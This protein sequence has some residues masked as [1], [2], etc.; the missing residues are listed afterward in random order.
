M[1][2]S[3]NIVH[4]NAWPFGFGFWLERVFGILD[5]EELRDFG[6][7][8]KRKVACVRYYL[9]MV[10]GTYKRKRERERERERVGEKE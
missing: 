2:H 3:S 1:H 9:D 10:K 6:D 7:K 8:E 4:D 5:I